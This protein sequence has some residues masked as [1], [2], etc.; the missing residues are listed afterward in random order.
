MRRKGGP[1]EVVHGPVHHVEGLIGRGLHIE[2]LCHE[3]AAVPHYDPAR[4]EDRA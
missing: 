1:H 3:D 2:Q 4:L